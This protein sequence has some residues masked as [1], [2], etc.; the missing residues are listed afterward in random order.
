MSRDAARHAAK[1]VGAA[2]WLHSRNA[3]FCTGGRTVGSAK[4]H[5]FRREVARRCERSLVLM[6]AEWQ[7][8]RAMGDE[9]PHFA[10]SEFG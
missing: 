2:E 3:C 10:G 8:Y 9:S 1:V 4:R 6:T 5:S 7:D